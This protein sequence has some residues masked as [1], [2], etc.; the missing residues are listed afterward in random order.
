MT[1]AS[2]VLRIDL[3]NGRLYIVVVVPHDDLEYRYLVQDITASGEI[4]RTVYDV[5]GNLK[6]MVELFDLRM[7]KNFT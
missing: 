4:I 5:T 6:A 2:T 7:T 1:L 3:D